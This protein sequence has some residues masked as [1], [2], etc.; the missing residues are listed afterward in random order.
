M[1]AK[2]SLA[3]GERYKNIATTLLILGAVIFGCHHCARFLAFNEMHGALPVCEDASRIVLNGT[4]QKIV[5]RKECWSGEV[6]TTKQYHALYYTP[7]PEN[8]DYAMR[9]MDLS[10]DVRITS[11]YYTS[12]GSCS[13]P[14]R[15]KSVSEPTMTLE[16]GDADLYQRK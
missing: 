12:A 15:F 11:K 5:L 16:I 7:I 2:N 3:S 6:T 1:D 9:C 10:R 8:T 13:F 14:M 4:K